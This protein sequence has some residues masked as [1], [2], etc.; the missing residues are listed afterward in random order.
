MSAVLTSPIGLRRGLGLRPRAAALPQHSD[1]VVVGGGL[2][3]LSIAWRLAGDGRSV[4]V[5]ERETVGAGASLAATGMLAPAAEHE[6][7]SDLLLPLALDSLCRWPVFRDAL[8]QASGV[9]IDYR[10]EGTLVL[11]IG[12]D[13]VERL[14]FRHDLQRRSGV[15]A[16]WLAG[17]EVRAR[18]PLLR[19]NV[20][21]G[22]FCPLDA[23]VDPRLVMLALVRA[24]EAAGVMI[25]EDL[26]ADDVTYRGGQASGIVTNRGTLAAET[27]ILA[28]GAWSGEGGLLT[29]A[30]GL[31]VRPIKGQSLALKTTTRTG[32]LAHM[33]WT[34]QI[35]MAPKGDGSLIVGATVEDCGF[36]DGVTAGGLFALLEGAR[37]VLPGV[38]E[39]EVEAVWSGFRPTSDDDAPI[40]DTLPNGLV[41]ATGHHRNGYL[42]APSTAD[43][44]VA[45]VE[46]GTVPEVC[47][48]FGL[49][50]F[51]QTNSGPMR[52]AS[53]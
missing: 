16:E 44:V 49:G 3:G 21:A 14:R 7:G 52:R 15:A 33:I 1:I 5:L 9:D 47:R 39:M 32:T 10:E 13:E 48:G 11:A 25:V 18:E 42:L 28:T 19:P 4:T 41:V 6:P 34:E 23:Q 2:I 45:L 12:R 20:T 27:V 51:A 36:R 38:E 35:H 17:A 24:C 31:P 40:I 43:A 53:A 46:T 37:R 30:L 29:D 50:R 8:Q 26:A 22:I